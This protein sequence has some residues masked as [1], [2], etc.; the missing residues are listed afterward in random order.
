MEN[1]NEK[2]MREMIRLTRMNYKMLKA[3]RRSQF[4]GRLFLFIFWLSLGGGVFWAYQNILLPITNQG[5]NL[6]N[7]VGG[8]INTVT[9]SI[10]N[11]QESLREVEE[12]KNEI[13][14]SRSSEGSDS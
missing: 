4:Y 3:L 12:L 9:D 1:N 14:E 11:V 6:V 2:M 7:Q 8:S 13:E 5:V 10:K